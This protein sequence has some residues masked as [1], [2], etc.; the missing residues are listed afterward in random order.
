M[1]V[2]GDADEQAV[3]DGEEDGD[4]NR[5]SYLA[6]HARSIHIFLLSPHTHMRLKGSYSHLK[7]KEK[8][9]RRDSKKSANMG[10]GETEFE[11][12]EHQAVILSHSKAFWKLWCLQHKTLVLILPCSTC[13]TELL[14]LSGTSLPLSSEG[15]LLQ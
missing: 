1:R 9:R 2:W 12:S 15:A 5:H 7:R 13:V 3:M 14:C 4:E 11:T 8:R 10:A 6:Q